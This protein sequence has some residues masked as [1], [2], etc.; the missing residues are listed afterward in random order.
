MR[1]KKTEGASRKYARRRA[2]RDL[3]GDG[4][5]GRRDGGTE[6]RTKREGGAGGG[7]GHR[8]RDRYAGVYGSRPYEIRASSSLPLYPPSV[9]YRRTHRVG[10]VARS[11]VPTGSARA[12]GT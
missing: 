11:R 10:L 7:R 9:L 3:G 2:R 5:E 6:E 8:R 4:G 12:P 1:K